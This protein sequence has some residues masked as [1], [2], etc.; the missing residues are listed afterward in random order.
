MMDY[1][2]K[3]IIYSHLQL[4]LE[5]SDKKSKNSAGRR[6]GKYILYAPLTRQGTHSSVG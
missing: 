3:L 1:P 5:Q 4:K 2:A 6:P